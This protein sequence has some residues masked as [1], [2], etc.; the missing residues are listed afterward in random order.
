MVGVSV[1]GLLAFSFLVG[2]WLAR[3]SRLASATPE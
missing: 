1:I 3:G 2:N